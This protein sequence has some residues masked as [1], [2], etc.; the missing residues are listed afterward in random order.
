MPCAERHWTGKQSE[1][2]KSLHLNLISKKVI[3]NLGIDM[4][5]QLDSSNQKS[6]VL[7]NYKEPLSVTI[8][9]KNRLAYKEPAPGNRVFY[10]EPA[11]EN[12]MFYKE[13]APENRMFY[14]ESA[15]ENRVFYKEPAPEYCVFY[16]K[17]APKNRV[18]YKEP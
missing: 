15:P 11:S 2:G 13:P 4:V 18:F 7:Y 14:K 1:C 12:R 5:L 8:A 17:P 6:H 3:Y 9:P 10:Q 16:K